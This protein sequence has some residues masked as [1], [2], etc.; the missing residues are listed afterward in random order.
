M[1]APRKSAAEIRKSIAQEQ[2]LLR[3]TTVVQ[4]PKGR[5]FTET[6][7]EPLDR[8]SHRIQRKMKA[9]ME[10]AEKGCD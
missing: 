7:Y 5:Q 2:L 9:R 10:T 1:A 8:P 6:D 3:R 4:E